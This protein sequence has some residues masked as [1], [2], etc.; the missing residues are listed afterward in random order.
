[1][2]REVL[3]VSRE[4]DVHARAVMAALDRLGTKSAILDFSRYP[5]APLSY[6]LSEDEERFDLFENF[7]LNI[8]QWSVW[9]RRPQAHI[10]PEGLAEDYADYAQRAT[11]SALLAML[12]RQAVFS[13]NPLDRSSLMVNKAHQLSLAKKVGLRFPDTLISNDPIVIKQYFEQYGTVMV[14]S[15]VMWRYRMLETRELSNWTELAEAALGASPIMLQQPI[16]G[17]VEYRVTIVGEAAFVAATEIDEENRADSRLS[18]RSPFRAAT[19]PSAT[20]EALM[21]FHALSGLE[22][23]AYDLRCD[24]AGNPHFLEV[25]PDGQYLW[26]EIE[27][28]LPISDAIAH[29]L[30]TGRIPVPALRG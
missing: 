6:V 12:A 19:L 17:R 25:N 23:G 29:R 2:D 5:G 18:E 3:I 24:E 16:R 7:D 21:R 30:A 13:M 4:D 8:G 14:K 11:R 28:D 27:S 20:M 15:P 26:I 1:M 9:Y 10:T 22:Y